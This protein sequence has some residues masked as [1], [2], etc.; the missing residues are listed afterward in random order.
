[1]S[2]AASRKP[3][4]FETPRPLPRGLISGQLARG[5]LLLC[6]DFDGTLAELTSDPW[7]AVPLPRAKNAIAE[8]ARHPN[9]LTLAIISGRD[10]DTLLGLLGL[11]DGILF[12]GTH[13]LEF[14]GRDGKRRFASGI[15]QSLN[16]IQMVREFL[17]RSIPRDRGFIVEDKGVALT[18]NYRNAQPDQAREALAAFDDFVSRRPTLQ[19]L[20]GKMIH[21]AIP[22]GIG[23]KGEA[24]EFF[25]RDAGVPGPATI[26]FGDDL[27]DE[28]AFRALVTHRGIGVLVGA[29]RPSFAQYRVDG[30]SEVADVLEDLI[31]RITS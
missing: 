19:V 18:L 28:D 2:R 12:A 29:E 1:L 16:D 15:D 4:P 24:L 27:T 3:E 31:V 8:L 10:L 30:P 14:I 6:L 5:H 25:M 11:R 23:G 9:Q 13:G 17:A 20:H 21:E 22:R 7:K 26:Y